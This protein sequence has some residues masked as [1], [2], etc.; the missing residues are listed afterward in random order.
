MAQD[1][2]KE[3]LALN[4]RLLDCIARADWSVYREMCD[5]SLTCFEP[6]ARGHL[7]QGLDFHEFYFKLG[8]VQGVHCTTM[9]SPHVRLMGDVAV[10]SYL[11]LNQRVQ[12]DGAPVTRAVEETRIWQRKDGQWKH[13]HFHRSQPD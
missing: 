9:A 11:R 5:P 2:N 6:E 13:V 7:V 8:P 12:T 1:A 10:V 3:L 4:Q